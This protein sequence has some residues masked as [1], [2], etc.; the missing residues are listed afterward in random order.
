MHHES[1]NINKARRDAL[2]ERLSSIARLCA[3]VTHDLGNVMGAIQ[4]N[5]SMMRHHLEQASPL[6]KNVDYIEMATSHA[7]L[8]SDM[9]KIYTQRHTA[10]LQTIDLYQ[11]LEPVI[12]TFAKG[13]PETVKF[14]NQCQ[15]GQHRILSCPLMFEHA[16]TNILQNAADA[17]PCARGII[18]IST[19][20]DAGHIDPAKGLYFGSQ[21]NGHP[22]IV[23]IADNGSGIT[24]DVM[25]HILEPFFS[26]RMRAHGLGLAPVVGLVFHCNAAVQIM[27]APSKGTTFRLLLPTAP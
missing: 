27:S 19:Y 21:S 25:E 12:A 4:S 8:L 17:L 5:A 22:V 10:P 18:E 7:N 13:L 9:L 20:H 6:Q 16:I 1:I 26:T 3:G 2:I 15:H 11:Q 23:E 24:A 14:N